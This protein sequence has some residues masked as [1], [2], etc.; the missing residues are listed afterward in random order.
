M[1]KLASI[2]INIM[3]S[4]LIDKSSDGKI[5][6]AKFVKLNIVD[7]AWMEYFQ[8]SSAHKGITISDT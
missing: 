3:Q 2:T 4:Y 5:S 8:N 7:K 1:I 6:E